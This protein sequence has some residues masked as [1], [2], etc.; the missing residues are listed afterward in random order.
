MSSELDVATSVFTSVRGVHWA[1]KVRDA[2]MIIRNSL[3]FIS[4]FFLKVSIL[5]A[6]R[7]NIFLVRQFFIVCLSQ[8]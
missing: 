6:V 2:S 1:C 5:S 7:E 4:L 3:I 8:Q